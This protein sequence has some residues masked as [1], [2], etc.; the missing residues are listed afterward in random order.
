MVFLWF[1]P[2]KPVLIALGPL[3]IVALGY[4]ALKAV[5]NA[6]PKSVQKGLIRLSKM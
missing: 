4:M 6:A 3:E 5:F 2:L 1:S